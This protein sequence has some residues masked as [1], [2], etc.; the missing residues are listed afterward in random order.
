MGIYLWPAPFSW[1]V[2][3][4]GQLRGRTE[5]HPPTDRHRYVASGSSY[6]AAMSDQITVLTLIFLLLGVACEIKYLL[7]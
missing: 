4:Y 1:L 6:G 5:A 7:R 2:P 3:R